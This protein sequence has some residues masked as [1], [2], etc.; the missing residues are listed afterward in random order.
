IPHLD[1]TCHR[2]LGTCDND[3]QCPPNVACRPDPI[4][5]ASDDIDHDGILD[6]LDNCP[7]I[8]NADQQ[9]LDGDGVG[10]AC[11]VQTCGNN[12]LDVAEVCD[13]NLG[14]CAGAASCLADC[15]CDC[16][17]VLTDTTARVLV[18]TRNNLGKLV[19]NL[20]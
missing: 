16:T 19:V 4:V 1:T 14:T 9:D 10:D 20:S 15:S 2:D 18:K 6:A 13:G 3:A 8:P 5:P 17:N 11:D 7:T 12:S